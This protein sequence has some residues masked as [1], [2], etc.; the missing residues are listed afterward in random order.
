M[1]LGD[2]SRLT[3]CYSA[4][5]RR[6]SDSQLRRSIGK[7]VSVTRNGLRSIERRRLTWPF[8]ASWLRIAASETPITLPSILA[9]GGPKWSRLRAVSSDWKSPGWLAK[10]GPATL[11]CTNT[12]CNLVPS[13]AR[14][15]LADDWVNGPKKKTPPTWVN[16]CLQLLSRRLGNWPRVNTWRRSGSNQSWES[17]TPRVRIPL[18][19]SARRWAMVSLKESLQAAK[20]RIC[21]ASLS[22]VS[23]RLREN[24]NPHNRKYGIRNTFAVCLLALRADSPNKYCW[25]PVHEVFQICEV[26]YGCTWRAGKGWRRA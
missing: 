18:D 2:P 6:T 19:R 25:T 20:L 13:P 7:A 14:S 16:W 4:C 21:F 9:T 24:E 15:T 3:V 26:T 22:S 1:I 11:G 10:I 8:T 5:D 12:C 17:R 23:A